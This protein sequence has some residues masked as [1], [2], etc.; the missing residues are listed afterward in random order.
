MAP[1]SIRRYVWET[2][3]DNADNADNADGAEALDAEYSISSNEGPSYSTVNP[4]QR[5][6]TKDGANSNSREKVWDQFPASLSTI[7]M[8]DGI[9]TSLEGGI[10]VED[11]T[12]FSLTRPVS[13]PP[14]SP[15]SSS[16]ASG[17]HT[18]VKELSERV[19]S[20]QSELH[21]LTAQAKETQAE[22]LRLR[23]AR[24][25]KTERARVTW[26]GKMN[27][28]QE[29]QNASLRKQSDFV[30]KLQGDVKS[31]R[32]KLS[33]LQEQLQLK[34]A[35]RIVMVDTLEAK[36]KRQLMQSRRQ[37]EA[38][39]K[40]SLEK[41][42]SARAEAMHKQ[43]T[44]SFTGKLERIVAEGKDSLQQKESEMAEKLHLIRV[45]LQK[46][47]DARLD[48]ALRSM[49]RSVR[50]EDDRERLRIEA[51]KSDL[52]RKHTEEVNLLK[53]RFAREEAALIETSERERKAESDI[54]LQSLQRLRE[55][56]EKQT[57]ELLLSQETTCHQASVDAQME[58]SRLTERLEAD[59]MAFEANSEAMRKEKLEGLVTHFK[60]EV[61]S[62]GEK[63]THLIKV[64]SNRESFYIRR[65]L[66][67]WTQRRRLSFRKCVV[68]SN[69]KQKR[70]N[71]MQR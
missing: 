3:T 39:E 36:A 16:S 49:R 45:E 54:T 4:P 17:I 9:K 24:D 35:D 29:E 12:Y 18:A 22:L 58:L 27:A 71:A 28:L 38:D 46:E 47:Y 44:A 57:A 61:G 33:G 2:W 65:Y 15:S 41:L 31:L 14:S 66:P 34:R 63:S 53:D 60:E 43:I 50:G 19:S 70:V 68:M 64:K 67:H 13:Q 10:D 6:K 55:A 23:A 59:L 21:A 40:L 52:A 7:D 69:L 51:R 62:K 8:T 1:K 48:E 32:G 42:G 5:S 26:A 11:Q 30:D 56:E 20:M 37:W 25:R